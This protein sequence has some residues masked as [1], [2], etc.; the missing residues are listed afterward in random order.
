MR[1][2][3][4]KKDNPGDLEISVNEFLA[5]EGRRGNKVLDIKFAIAKGHSAYSE[6]Y[7]SAM[8]ITE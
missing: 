6:K 2:K 1:V 3:I 5:N 7:W 8:I 4:I